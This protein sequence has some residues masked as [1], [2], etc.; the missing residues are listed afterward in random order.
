MIAAP[1]QADQTVGSRPPRRLIPPR[2]FALFA[3]WYAILLA[4]GVWI[5]V[6]IPVTTLVPDDPASDP[7]WP[8][9]LSSLQPDMPLAGLVAPWHRFDSSHYLGMAQDGYSHAAFTAFAPLYPLV[10]GALDRL[11]GGLVGGNFVLLGMLVNLA[12]SA[13]MTIALHQLAAAHFADARRPVSVVLLVL[14]FPTAFYLIAPYTESLYLLLVVS[15]FLALQRR[16]WLTAGLLSVLAVWA[17][18]HG[19]ILIAPLVWAAASHVWQQPAD[20]RL[21]EAVRVLPAALGAAVGGATLMLFIRLQGFGDFTATTGSAWT[22][23]VTLP[24]VPLLTYLDRAVSGLALWHEHETVIMIAIMTALCVIAGA[25]ALRG[26]MRVEYVLYAAATLLLSLSLSFE[27]RQYQS[28]FRH[29][30]LL[31][32]CFFVLAGMLKSRAVRSGWIGIMILW[33]AILILRFT[34]WIWVA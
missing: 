17:R 16:W 20:R 18:F 15:V 11:I 12:L 10:V 28:T 9:Y 19:I 3:V 30:L 21:R 13:A 27:G 31:F 1:S 2:V 14:T 7:A 26:Q 5:T 34:H 23:A 6:Q 22:T 33:Q 32:P 8:Y 29:L 25:Q 4:Y 24:H